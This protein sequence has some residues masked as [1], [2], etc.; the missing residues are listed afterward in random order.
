MKFKTRRFTPPRATRGGNT[1]F[2]EKEVEPPLTGKVQ[3]LKAAQ[4]E[5]RLARVLDIKIRKRIVQTYYFR[6][7]PGVPKGI[8]GWKEL[9]FLIIP[10]GRPLAVSVKGEDFVHRSSASK[11]QD[12]LNDIIILARLKKLGYDI[13]NIISVPAEKLKTQKDAERAVKDIGIP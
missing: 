10:N 11:E 7:S 1:S 6:T 3:G 4:G 2:F 9:D 12:K 5:E 8:V 13:P